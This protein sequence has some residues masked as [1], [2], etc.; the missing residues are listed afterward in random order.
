MVVKG[1]KMGG[2]RLSFRPASH[3]LVAGR[4]AS[5]DLPQGAKNPGAAAFAVV[6]PSRPKSYTRGRLQVATLAATHA[7]QRRRVRE[8]VMSEREGGGFIN[9]RR[10]AVRDIGRSAGA[11]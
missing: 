5:A 2:G 8:R 3:W 4:A 6:G 7:P 1:R 10:R 11:R 9:T